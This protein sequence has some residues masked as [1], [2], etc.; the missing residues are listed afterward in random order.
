MLS[1]LVEGQ[2]TGQVSNRNMYYITGLYVLQA[3]IH[4]LM[5]EFFHIAFPVLQTRAVPVNPKIATPQPNS[6]VKGL[7]TPL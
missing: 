1:Y 6:I 5:D 2:L 4:I 3:N 7:N